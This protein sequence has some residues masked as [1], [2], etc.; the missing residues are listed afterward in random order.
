M[1]T[2]TKLIHINTEDIIK[3]KL[4]NNNHVKVMIHLVFQIGID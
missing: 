3:I 4:K 2:A 1:F